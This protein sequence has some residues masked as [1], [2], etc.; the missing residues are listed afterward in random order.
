MEIPAAAGLVI[1]VLQRRT[2]FDSNAASRALRSMSGRALKS[3]PSR[4]RRSNRKN[5]SPPA[6]PASDASLDHAERGDAVR[7]DAAELAVEISLARPEQRQGSGDRGIFMRPVEPGAG[8]QPDR[9]AIEARV[10][11]V[12]VE[13]DFVQPVRSFRRV[14][15]ELRQLRPNPFRQG[16]LGPPRCRS[17]HGDYRTCSTARLPAGSGRSSSDSGRVRS[18]QASQSGRSRTTICRS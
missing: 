16:G 18:S 8:Q 12:G 5:T 4:C 17:R 11:A 3:S 10:H 13:L 1:T 14:L 2:V 7:A 15:H 6:W 9:A